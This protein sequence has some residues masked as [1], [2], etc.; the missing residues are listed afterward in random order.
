[1]IAALGCGGT[2]TEERGRPIGRP[3]LTSVALPLALYG[4]S[5]PDALWLQLSL[6][7][8]SPGPAAP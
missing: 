4:Q 5:V 8:D 6:Q 3:P 2:D 7:F 1:M